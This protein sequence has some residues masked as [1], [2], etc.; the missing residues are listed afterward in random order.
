[1]IITDIWRTGQCIAF[2]IYIKH[3]KDP[4]IV[5]CFGNSHLPNAL[6]LWL[7]ARYA[8]TSENNRIL[9]T[10]RGDDHRFSLLT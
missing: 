4:L 8:A 6:C 9:V 10:E 3:T 2:T 1:M 7:K 5:L